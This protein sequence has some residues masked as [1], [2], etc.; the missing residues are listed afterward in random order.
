MH[1]PGDQDKAGAGAQGSKLRAAPDSVAP[2]LDLMVLFAAIR[3]HGSPEQLISDG[4]G[5]FKAK[6]A[7]RIYA[8]LE[9][10]KKQIDKRQAWQNL[11]STT[12][13]YVRGATHRG[14]TVHN[15]AGQEQVC[16]A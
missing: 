16:R 14:P 10:E 11:I 5:I 1:K 2:I 7:L 9:I 15:L 6:Q 4:G 12:A 3:Q 13:I 8:A